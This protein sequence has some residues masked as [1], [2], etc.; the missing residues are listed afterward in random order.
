MKLK[1]FHEFYRKVVEARNKFLNEQPNVIE[2]DEPA[3][4][5]SYVA[6][7]ESNFEVDIDQRKSS[8]FLMLIELAFAGMNQMNGMVFF[9]YTIM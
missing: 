6:C 3:D 4:S 8:N 2:I 7:E 9:I 1:K 5:T